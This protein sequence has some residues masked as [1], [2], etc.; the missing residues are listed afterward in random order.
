MIQAVISL[1]G[2]QYLVSEGKTF[3]IDKHVDVEKD[4]P[5][6]KA[7]KNLEI[8]KVLLTAVDD[9]VQIGTPLVEGASVTLKIVDQG[10]ADKIAIR[11]FQAKSRHRR[12]IGHRQPQTI[13]Q[14][15]KINL[16]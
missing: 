4:L 8:N 9:Q 11:R 12:H 13:L 3:K 5:S 10:K 16:K 6:G 1:A 15:S 14:V 2:K 7:D